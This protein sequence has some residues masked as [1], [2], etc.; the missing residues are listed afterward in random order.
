MCTKWVSPGHVFDLKWL[1]LIKN[2]GSCPKIFIMKNGFESQ[3]LLRDMRAIYPRLEDLAVFISMDESCNEERIDGISIQP[4]SFFDKSKG[5][6]VI[7]MRTASDFIMAEKLSQCGLKENAD[8]YEAGYFLD[9]VFPLFLL[10]SNNYLFDKYVQIELT[11][12]CTLKC[13]KCAHLCNLEN[14]EIIRELSLQQAIESVDAYFN[15]VDKVGQF[16]VLGGEPLIYPYLVEFLAYIGKR[17]KS[18][19]VQITITTNCTVMPGN[20][21]LSLC[22]EYGVVFI[23]SDY[24]PAVKGKRSQIDAIKSVLRKESIGYCQK[25]ADGRKWVDLGLTEISKDSQYA[26]KVYKQCRSRCTEIRLGAYYFCIIARCASEVLYDEPNTD[27]LQLDNLNTSIG[28]R[29]LYEYSLGFNHKGFLEMCKH[30]RGMN[31]PAKYWV[32][33]GVQEN[34]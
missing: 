24:R 32:E 15:V 26:A 19:I 6:L 1:E 2:H 29:I 13:K 10:Y 17:Y 27:C 9:K 34:E 22:R 5:I 30:C 16:D 11:R 23:L 21:L 14:H 4:F 18:K 28:K 8:Y 25:Y 3:L 33:P 7:A 20:E 31:A 12:K